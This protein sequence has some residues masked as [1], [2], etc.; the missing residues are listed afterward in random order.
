[1]IRTS[2]Q[3]RN[4]LYGG[5]VGGGTLATIASGADGPSNGTRHGTS[6]DNGQ[7]SL[8]RESA[9]VPGSFTLYPAQPARVAALRRFLHADP[10]GPATWPWSGTTASNRAASPSRSACAA[11]PTPHAS[12][13][14]SPPARVTSR[15]RRPA[16]SRAPAARGAASLSH[17]VGGHRRC[18]SR[19]A[20][21]VP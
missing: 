4:T 15:W 3:T 1:L 14:C 18:V 13:T 9:L 2:K 6:V 12:T 17:L 10:A 8:D 16:R 5:A 21:D 19:I 20:S 7:A 11:A